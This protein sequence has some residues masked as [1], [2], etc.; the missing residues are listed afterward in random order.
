MTTL[1]IINKGDNSLITLDL[2]L[3]E[4]RVFKKFLVIPLNNNDAEGYFYLLE[5][6]QFKTILKCIKDNLKDFYAVKI[7]KLEVLK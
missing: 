6:R 5:K 1:N 7:K 3:N 2:R 4:I